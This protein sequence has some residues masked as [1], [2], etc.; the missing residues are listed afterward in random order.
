[1]SFKRNNQR[2]TSEKS[3]LRTL[4]DPVLQRDIKLLTKYYLRG[5][6]T[7]HF[8]ATVPILFYELFH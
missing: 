4:E 3:K 5:K 2:N 6:F 1:M 8:L 7:I